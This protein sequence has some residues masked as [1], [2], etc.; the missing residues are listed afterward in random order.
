MYTTSS[1]SAPIAHQGAQTFTQNPNSSYVG[2]DNKHCWDNCQVPQIRKST[3]LAKKAK[4]IL[5]ASEPPTCEIDYSLLPQEISDYAK[6]CCQFSSTSDLFILTSLLTSISVS[7]RKKVYM[8]QGAY[9][10]KLKP[11][12][13]FCNIGK[14]GTFKSTALKLGNKL[15]T[16]YHALASEEISELKNQLQDTE[17][18][19]EKRRI[20]EQ[21]S[22]W[23]HKKTILASKITTEALVS[24]LKIQGGGAFFLDEMGAWLGLQANKTYLADFKGFLTELYENDSVLVETKLGGQIEIR[25]PFLSICGVTTLQWLENA[26]SKEDVCSGFFARFLIF[27]PNTDDSEK[28][29]SALPA[30]QDF[31]H[32]YLNKIKEIVDCVREQNVKEMY[33]DPDA[34]K[35]FE[36][37][38]QN[39]YSI[40][41]QIPEEHHILIDPYVRRWSPHVLKLAMIFEQFFNPDSNLISARAIA[42][43]AELV[44]HAIKSTLY[45]LRA[46]LGESEFQRDC[47][48]VMQFIAQKGGQASRQQILAS[49]RLDGG[50]KVYDEILDHLIEAGQV[51]ITKSGPKKDWIYSLA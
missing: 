15:A 47:R 33:V 50:L 18:E 46:S 28:I 36:T 1:S 34:K 40:F 49:K 44:E 31:D 3:N 14:S 41:Q 22:Q 9:F 48:K 30:K 13:W 11:N 16:Q 4:E 38:H 6:Y 12:V 32:F 2:K 23:E 19:K 27:W 20:E 39:I 17:D 37:V 24:R 8:P 45:L 26:I 7:I 29:P 43:G 21:I 25:D 5:L 10:C 51:E 42:A 35:L